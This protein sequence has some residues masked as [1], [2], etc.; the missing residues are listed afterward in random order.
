VSFKLAIIAS[1]KLTG[2]HKSFPDSD[3]I[4]YDTIAEF[5]VDSLMLD[6]LRGT[7]VFSSNCK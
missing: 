1:L 7:A 3:T 5:N 2:A 4:R 6:L